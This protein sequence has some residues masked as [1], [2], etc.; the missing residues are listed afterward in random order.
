[1]PTHPPLLPSISSAV[2][3]ITGE[4]VGLITGDMQIGADSSCLIMTTEIL[5]SML[6][7]G[8]DLVRD[9]EWVIFDEVSVPVFF[10]ASVLPS[11]F[12]QELALYCSLSIIL[13]C[14][15]IF[16]ASVVAGTLYQ[17]LG[18]RGGV[19]GGH[20]YA[21]RLCQLNFPFRYHPQHDRIFRLDWTHETEAGARHSD[22]LSPCTT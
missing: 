18:T 19:G 13:H 10:S 2:S 17:R 12:A 6:Y 20:H 21:S 3:I 15:S 9:I 14:Q 22:K 4:D 11:S 8:A 1:M 5:R 7:R 16:H